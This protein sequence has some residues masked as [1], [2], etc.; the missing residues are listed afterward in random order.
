MT[1]HRRHL[2][3]HLELSSRLGPTHSLK[4]GATELHEVTLTDYAIRELEWG[5]TSTCPS[6]GSVSYPEGPTWTEPGRLLPDRKPWQGSV[7]ETAPNF[8]AATAQARPGQRPQL[9]VTVWQRQLRPQRQASVYRHNPVGF[10][11]QIT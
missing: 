6:D 7:S 5:F 9:R 11:V 4:P 2:T 1:T 3:A 8:L 10:T